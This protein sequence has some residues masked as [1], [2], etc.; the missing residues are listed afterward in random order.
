VAANRSAIVAADLVELPRTVEQL[1]GGH[2]VRVSRHSSIPAP[3]STYRC[4]RPQAEQTATMRPVSAPTAATHGCVAGQG[5]SSGGWTP[6]RWLTLNANP[7]GSLGALLEDVCRRGS[8]C[9]V[10]RIGLD[11]GKFDAL[12]ARW[13]RTRHDDRGYRRTGSARCWLPRT[14]RRWPSPT[15]ARGAGP[16]PSPISGT[17]GSVAARGFVTVTGATRLADLTRYCRRSVGVRTGCRMHSR[18]P[19]TD[20]SGARCG[21]RL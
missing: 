13:Q 16:R 6:G 5:G 18:R 10:P 14:R 9:A 21:G 19:G 17:A 11:E 8:R 15:A 7:D 20:G 2:T 3:G 4:S 12:A 1:S